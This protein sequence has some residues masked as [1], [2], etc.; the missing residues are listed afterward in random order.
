MIYGNHRIWQVSLSIDSKRKYFHFSSLA[1]ATSFIKHYV[2]DH[3]EDQ[4]H[5]PIRSMNVQV[6]NAQCRLPKIIDGMRFEVW[7]KSKDYRVVTKRDE[8]HHILQHLILQK[9]E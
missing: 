9:K 5:A 7:C 6:Y 8:N 3:I 1:R 4:G 2:W